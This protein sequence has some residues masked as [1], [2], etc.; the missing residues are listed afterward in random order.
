MQ[1][2]LSNYQRNLGEQQFGSEIKYFEEVKSTNDEMW[3]QKIDE[4]SLIIITD[5]QTKGRGRR[6][7]DWFSKEYESLTFSIGIINKEINLL[8][9]KISISIVDAINNQTE[10]H[11]EIKWPNDILINKKKIAGILI[12]RK[13]KI[14]N[15]GIGINVN[16]RYDDFPIEIR[17]NMTSLH[18]EAGKRFSRE[19][20]LAEV[21]KMINYNLDLDSDSTIAKWTSM[22]SH[23]NANIEFY[24]NN[25]LIKGVF[26]GINK[27]GYAIIKSDTQIDHYATGIIEL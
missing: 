9:Q 1:F 4:K 5:K 3:K 24:N 14:I 27:S 7:N 8:T 21:I 13:N 10:L 2:N 20:L 19:K 17:N 26:I 12:E 18:V 15:I 23:N 6:A 16:I 25:K 11:S 22:C